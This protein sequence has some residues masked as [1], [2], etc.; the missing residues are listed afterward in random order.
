MF[1][2][3]VATLVAGFAGAGVALLLN[4][5]T[6]GRMPKWAMPAGAA[7]AMIVATAANEYGWYDRTQQTLPEGFKIVQTVEN[8]SFYRP[9][10]YINPFVERFIAVDEPSLRTHDDKPA[11]RMVDTYFL[12]RWSAPEKMV[13][14]ADCATGRRAPLIDGVS[15]NAGGDISGID[16]FA[17]GE[18]DPLVTAICNLEGS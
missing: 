4:K 9:W 13:V 10:T 14:L 17:P 8:Q 15:F 11:L 16:W 7:L 3:M 12:G 5:L 18:G 2:E 1:F 6:R